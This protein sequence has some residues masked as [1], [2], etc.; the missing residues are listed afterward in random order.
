[1]KKLVIAAGCLALAT[2]FVGCGGA[3]GEDPGEAYMPDMYYSRAYET[4]NY[5]D[6]GGELDSLRRRGIFY[7]AMPVEG[8]IARGDAMPYH[9]VSTGDSARMAEANSF[10]NPLD[11]MA[12]TKPALKEAERLYLV[13]CG[14]C[15]GTSLKGDGPIAASGAYPAAPKDLTAPDSKGFSDGHFFY[16]IT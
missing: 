7:N 11:S 9:F 12:A 13:N 8:T 4:Y 14:I 3:H 10:G 16:V 6:V 5:N 15:H 2:G 1:M